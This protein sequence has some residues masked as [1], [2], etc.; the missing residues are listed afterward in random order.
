MSTKNAFSYPIMNV[1]EAACAAQR[2]NGAYEKNDRSCY[3]QGTGENATK[4]IANREIMKTILGSEGKG[5]YQILPEDSE[6]AEKVLGYAK[7]MILEVVKGTNNSFV[8]LVA[9]IAQKEEI[10][11][12]LHLAIIA[13]L[14]NSYFR[15]RERLDQNMKLFGKDNIL[16]EA[17]G[18]KIQIEVEAIR[19][20]YS[21]N[22]NVYYVTAIA[23][24]STVFY[25]SKNKIETGKRFRISGTVKDHKDNSRTQLTRVKILETLE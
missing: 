6:L 23:G 11:S 15:S 4:I 20:N 9:E 3:A 7:S 21:D 14:P 16:D 22:W 17:I 19:C 24:N 18:N 8:M 25:S 10:T 1:V 2:I 5:E 12:P 13:S